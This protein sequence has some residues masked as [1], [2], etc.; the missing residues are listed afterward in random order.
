[1]SIENIHIKLVDIIIHLVICLLFLYTCADCLI[2]WLLIISERLC[3]SLCLEN[4]MWVF[5]M[6]IPGEILYSNK[7]LIFISYYIKCK[8][9]D[10]IYVISKSK[11]YLQ[12]QRLAICWNLIC[13]YGE[14]MKFSW[15]R[16]FTEYPLAKRNHYPKRLTS[17]YWPKNI[18]QWVSSTFLMKFYL[19]NK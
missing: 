13:E 9:V 15:V 10:W 12:F 3:F 16:F 17:E 7:L 18:Y 11:S 19:K 2:I 5:K 8:K 14:D 1:M 4:T 6:L